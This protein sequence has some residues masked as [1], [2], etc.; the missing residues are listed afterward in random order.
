[1]GRLHEI[2]NIVV[3]V[4]KWVSFVNAYKRLYKRVYSLIYFWLMENNII[5]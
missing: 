1:M 4:Y 5:I 2:L 3:N